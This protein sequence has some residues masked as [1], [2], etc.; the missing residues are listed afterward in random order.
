MPTAIL[1]AITQRYSCRA[2]RDTPLPADLVAQIAEAGLHAP[3]AHN[4]QPWR[5]CWTADPDLV[6]SLD[7]Q[8]VAAFAQADPEGYQRRGAQ[9]TTVF[10]HAPAMVLIVQEPGRG[11]ETGLVAATIALAAAGL[12]VGSVIVGSAALLFAGPGAPAVRARLSVPEGF[13]FG[14]AI[15]LGYPAADDAGRP[16]PIDR[17]KLVPVP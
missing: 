17:A 16:H 14:T 9:A 4:S 5:I 8:A 11:L 1:S 10:Y 3:S 13:E 2:Y 12:G 6:K 15:L 7:T